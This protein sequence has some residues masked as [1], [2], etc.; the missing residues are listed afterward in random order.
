MIVDDEPFVIEFNVRMGDPE[1][2]V[3]IPLLDSSFFA[4][5]H[6]SL[7][8]KLKETKLEISSQT[9]VTVV[10]ASDGYP[11]KYDKGMKISGINESNQNQVFHAGTGLIDGDFVTSGGRVL[12]VVGFGDDLQKAIINAYE[13][14]EEVDFKGKFFR[15]DIGK[16]GLSY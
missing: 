7:E 3:V 12:N 14:A 6:D 9:A 10:L 16:K 4:L 11:G 1:T 8:G 5:L 15:T 2:Q 13:L